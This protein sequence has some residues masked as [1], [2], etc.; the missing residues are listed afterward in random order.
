[1]VGGS[2]PTGCN[3]GRCFLHSHSVCISIYLRSKTFVKFI[4]HKQFD[5]RRESF[6]FI[7]QL[8][9]NRRIGPQLMIIHR[10]MKLCKT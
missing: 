8:R 3:G 5:V 9:E 2:R 7:A 4:R 10:R 1:M 6:I